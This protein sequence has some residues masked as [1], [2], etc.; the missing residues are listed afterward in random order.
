[1]KKQLKEIPASDNKDFWLGDIN[2]NEPKVVTD[3]SSCQH[4]FEMTDAKEA[5]CEKCGS[6]IFIEYG[7]EIKE[8]HLYH[9]GEFVV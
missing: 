2:L 9:L 7:D 3:G 8:G 6:G 1:M 4:T 5:V